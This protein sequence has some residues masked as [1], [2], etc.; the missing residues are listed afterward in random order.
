MSEGVEAT[1]TPPAA[2]IEPPGRRLS[3]LAAAVGS[4][5]GWKR[6]AITLGAY[7]ASL[8]IFGLVVATQHAN[9]F[10]VFNAIIHSALFDSGSIPQILLRAVP[11]SL[12]ALAVSIPARAGLVNV[13]GEGQLIVGAIAA[14]GVALYVLG[15][16]VPAGIALPLMALA[17]IGA[18]AAWGALAAVLRVVVN[19]NEAVTTLLMNFIANDILLY[20]LYQPWKDPAGT[21]QPQSKPLTANTTLPHIFGATLNVGVIVALAGAIGVFVVLRR[22]G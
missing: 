17:G 14:T 22:S 12:A 8:A 16:A 11:I 2:M 6:V 18:G 3:S 1:A 19:A 7:V 10:G 21:G 9:P 4:A 20:L 13:G 15:P 5:E